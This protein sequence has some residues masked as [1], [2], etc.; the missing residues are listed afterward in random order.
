MHKM[1]AADVKI[2]WCDFFIAPQRALI[3]DKNIIHNKP[4]INI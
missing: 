4:T 1:Q 2:L 3:P